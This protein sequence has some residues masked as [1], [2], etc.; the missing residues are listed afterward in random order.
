MDA[1]PLADA[2][3]TTRWQLRHQRQLWIFVAAAAIEILVV[4]FVF[5]SPLSQ[6]TFWQDA[7][8]AVGALVKVALAAFALLLVALWPRRDELIETYRLAAAQSSI[9]LLVFANIA[10]FVTLLAVRVAILLAPEPPSY[11]LT[12][13]IAVLLATGASL[14]FLAAPPAFWWKLPS[15]APVE[16]AVALVGGATALLLGYVAQQGWSTLAGTT[17][18][19]AHWILSLYEANVILDIDGQILGVGNFS[20][21]INDRCSGY[22]GISLVLIFLSIYMWVFRQQLRF[23]NVLL[24]LPLGVATIWLLNGLRIAILISIGAH[25]SPEMA[26]QG[27]HTQAG[28]ISFL[29]VTLA[30]IAISR[31][32]P[33]FSVASRPDAIA[34][35]AGASDASSAA[36]D[37]SLAYLAPFIAMLAANLFASAFAPHDQWLYA[38]KV[39]AIG[40]ALWWFRDVY[41]PLLTGCSWLSIAVGATVGVLWI[42]TDPGRG[43]QVP[44]GDWIAVQP[45]ELVAVWLTLRALGTVVFVP[46]A[47]EL[48][49]RGFLARWLISTRFESVDF[50]Q[51]R[52]LAFIVSSMA[53]GIMHE[54]WLAAFLAGAVFALLMYRTRRLSD[55]VVAHS[56]ANLAIFVWAVADRQWSLL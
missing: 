42:V 7:I 30:G 16:I 41:V 17:L 22:E 28:W 5:D 51:F 27:F 49:F 19:F 2:I 31:K 47:E 44:L 35:Q 46:I 14:A 1:P 36:T 20:V 38:V 12:A 54:R 52:P 3:A 24:L 26:I 29:C 8:N 18:I 45:F 10:A 37:Q 13:Y 15:I 6:L 32:V 55:A 56:I 40:A 50:G 11:L 23:P 34:A 43:E 53:F 9:G 48:A 21:W 39:V 4:P 25:V 33:F